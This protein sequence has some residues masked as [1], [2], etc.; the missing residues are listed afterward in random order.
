[1]VEQQYPM[2]EKYFASN[3]CSDRFKKQKNANFFDKTLK[4]HGRWRLF[5]KESIEN[6]KIYNINKGILLKNFD[7]TYKIKKVRK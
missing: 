6:I 7:R 1:M 4:N 3:S 2:G 5:S